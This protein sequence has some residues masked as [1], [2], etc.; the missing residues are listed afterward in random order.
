MQKLPPLPAG[1]TYDEETPSDTVAND[2]SRQSLP[3]GFTYDEETPVPPKQVSDDEYEAEAQK[4][5]RSGGTFDDLVNYQKSVGRFNP[6]FDQ[7]DIKGI[8]ERG[9]REPFRFTRERTG[10]ENF[11][12]GAIR[13]NQQIFEGATQL[14]IRLADTLGLDD[15]TAA[16]LQQELGQFA[17]ERDASE[18]QGTGGAIGEF[19]GQLPITAAIPLGRFGEATNLAGKAANAAGL[20]ATGAA[21]AA[22]SGAEETA[23]E[24]DAKAVY[25]GALTLLGV[26]LIEKLAGKVS[27]AG[28]RKFADRYSQG[29]GKQFFKD[30]KLTPAGR[31]FRTRLKH[32]DPSIDDDILDMAMEQIRKENPKRLPDDKDVVN[33]YVSRAQGVPLTT[34]Q[35]TRNAE[36]IQDLESAAT[37]TRGKAAQDQAN[38]VIKA[39]DDAIKNNIAGIKGNRRTSAEAADRIGSEAA[40]AKKAAQD[41]KNKLYEPLNQ[42]SER[43]TRPSDLKSVRDSTIDDLGETGYRTLKKTEPEVSAYIDELSALSSKKQV[44]FGELWSLSKRVNKAYRKQFPEPSGTLEKLRN[45]LRKFIDEAPADAFES[46][47]R[48]VFDQLKKA[49]A[50]NREYREVYGDV[51]GG[52]SAR[53]VKDIIDAVEQKR[54]TP[55][56]IENAIFGQSKSLSSAQSK[57]AAV[58]IERLAK[59]APGTRQMARDITINRLMDNMLD[60]GVEGALNPMQAKKAIDAAVN[61]NMSLLKAIGLNKSEITSLKANA[62][63]TALKLAPPGARARGSS[64]TNREGFKKALGAVLQGSLRIAGVSA[65]G[66]PGLVVAEVANAGAKGVGK[67]VQNRSTKR[68]LSTKSAKEALDKT[69]KLTLKALGKTTRQAVASSSNGDD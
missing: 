20:Y 31:V 24:Q 6:D 36:Q 66:V 44:S 5:V 19:L 30:G 64:A 9:G 45:N 23:A 22:V 39:Q 53:A 21:T 57:Q 47:E 32:A 48:G 58:T 26:P 27:I 18:V 61:E 62:H 7:S 54:A 60:K 34:G 29:V 41:R 10:A 4:I 56:L 52:R 3:E 16:R 17:K 49:N 43:L 14:G 59:A 2:N 28:V 42:S 51:K 11:A 67:V 37:G 25:G 38:E 35:K 68:A 69:D 1:F 65:G 13:G 15:A 12:R 46:G 33:E 63:L 40:T 8:I 50:A 55:E